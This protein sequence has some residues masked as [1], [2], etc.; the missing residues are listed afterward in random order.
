MTYAL[1]LR[2]HQPRVSHPSALLCA[3]VGFHRS[4]RTL[5]LEL[6]QQPAVFFAQRRPID[7]IWPVAQRFR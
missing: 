3:R 2:H 1:R 5:P 6:R 4:N 7:Q